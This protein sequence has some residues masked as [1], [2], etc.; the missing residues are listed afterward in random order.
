M[1]IRDGKQLK[2]WRLWSKFMDFFNKKNGVYKWI[3][4]FKEG[5]D[6]FEDVDLVGR[7]KASSNDKIIEAVLALI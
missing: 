1:V 7:P 2:F 6:D 4:R 3:Q 5:R